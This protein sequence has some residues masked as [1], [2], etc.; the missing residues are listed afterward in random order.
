MILAGAQWI[1]ADEVG[2]T[3]SGPPPQPTAV[4]RALPGTV[5]GEGEIVRGWLG[6]DVRDFTPPPPNPYHLVAVYGALVNGVAASSPAAQAGLLP[7]DVVTHF[8]D[9]PVATADALNR[10]VLGTAPGTIVDL[11]V[12]RN[13]NELKLTAQVGRLDDRLLV[14]AGPPPAPGDLGLTVDEGSP[15]AARGVVVT[16]VTNGSLAAEA[17]LGPDDVIVS[18]QGRPVRDVDQYLALL[19]HRDLL[20]RSV[21]LGVRSAGGTERE[22]Y[23]AP[24]AG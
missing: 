17:G 20:T 15:A 12:I 22:V 18:V 13:G 23:L 5:V 3:I 24:A 7:G 16:T 9:R 2:P 11:V 4:S 8:A 14:V 1:L 19:G 21:Q 10:A 6:L